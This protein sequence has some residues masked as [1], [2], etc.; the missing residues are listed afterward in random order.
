VISSGLKNNDFIEEK[1]AKSVN[2]NVEED[3][4]IAEVTAVIDN[5][6]NCVISGI[7]GKY[8]IIIP[9]LSAGIHKLEVCAED[10]FGIKTT[11]TYVIN[12]GEKTFAA[13]NLIRGE[14]ITAKATGVLNN[15]VL[16]IASYKD[17]TMIDIAVDT[18]KTDGA[19]LSESLTP[20][21]TADE[22]RSFICDG[23]F[24]PLKPA[25]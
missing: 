3:G 9:A 18:A 4:L 17:G 12:A 15:T 21:E 6:T 20:N 10:N 22:Y 25:E 19:T 24:K 23:N 8:S 14:I 5:N 7:N 2:V 11:K 13:H 1:I 16:L